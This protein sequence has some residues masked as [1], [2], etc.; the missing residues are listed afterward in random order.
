[1]RTRV[2]LKEGGYAFSSFTYLINRTDNLFNNQM[3]IEEKFSAIKWTK[4]TKEFWKQMTRTG[5][6]DEECL[7]SDGNHFPVSKTSDKR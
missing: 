4:K 2:K 5:P 3:T 1:M 6:L 7:Q